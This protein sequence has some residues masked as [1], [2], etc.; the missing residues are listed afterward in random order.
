MA[1]QWVINN[2]KVKD[3]TIGGKKVK[4][5]TLANGKVINFGTTTSGVPTIKAREYTT[6]SYD[7]GTIKLTG[8]NSPIWESIADT[9]FSTLSKKIAIEVKTKITTSTTDLMFYWDG[10]GKGFSYRP[11]SNFVMEAGK[12][13]VIEQG[14]NPV[15]LGEDGPS[16][17]PD[18]YILADTNYTNITINGTELNV[19][20]S[21]Q[22]SH[23]FQVNFPNSGNSVLQKQLIVYFKE[24]IDIGWG[25][26]FYLSYAQTIIKTWSIKITG[27]TRFHWNFIAG[28]KYL[29]ENGKD[30]VDLGSYETTTPSTPTITTNDYNS[31]DSSSTLGLQLVGVLNSQV[32][33]D[34]IIKQKA[35]A[36]KL[37]PTIVVEIKEGTSLTSGDGTFSIGDGES[38][39]SDDLDNNWL[40]YDTKQTDITSYNLIMG[41]KYQFEQGKIPTDL[42]EYGTTVV[43]PPAP[44]GPIIK[45]TEYV[46]DIVASAGYSIRVQ[47]IQ[48]DYFK[49][50]TTAGSTEAVSFDIEIRCAAPLV[51][52]GISTFRITDIVNRNHL[53]VRVATGTFTLQNGHKY[54]IEP[55]KDPVDLGIY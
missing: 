6:I 52:N 44:T 54:H 21:E 51:F 4:S 11:Q 20:T 14:K 35:D 41:H 12:T 46:N 50:I 36:N 49:R 30:P 5:L 31:I 7:S 34:A 48:N 2:K 3:W 26:I 43:T 22:S 15:V 13:Y 39:T 53:D 27:A 25:T 33:K 47:N 45:A 40:F 37:A 9:S 24:N 10:T 29:F 19:D 23:W 38:S 8:G 16:I 17:S 32:F 1:S 28:H 55:G 18:A 42:G